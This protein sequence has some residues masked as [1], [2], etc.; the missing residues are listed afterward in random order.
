MKEKLRVLY[1]KYKDLIP[2][3]I[4]GVLTTVV[5]YVAYWLFAHPLDCGTLFSNAAAWVL[6]VLFAYVT[7][8]RWVFH[9]T[10]SGA[11]EIGREFAAFVAARLGTG[12][13]DMAFMYVF[14]DLIGWNDMII[15]LVSNVFV[16]V[17]NYILSKFF[18]FKK[19]EN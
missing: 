5:N 19:K 7:N 1:D 18:I 4:F 3:F 14:V 10:A 2:Y 6:A 15:K 12:L 17:L 16:V 8:R 11:K 13:M 9:S